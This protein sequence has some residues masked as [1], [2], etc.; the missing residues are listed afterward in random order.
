MLADTLRKLERNGF[1][2]RKVY[3]SV[4]PKVEYQLHALGASLAAQL[5]LLVEW[6]NKNHDE[7]RTARSAYKPT[8]RTEAL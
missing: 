2:S 6:A 4:P 5:Q 8:E 1:V 3:P 7:I